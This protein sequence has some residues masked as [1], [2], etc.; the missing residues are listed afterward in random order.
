MTSSR[1]VYW[2]ASVIIALITNEPGRGAASSRLFEGIQQAPGRIYISTIGIA[3]CSGGQSVARLSGLQLAELNAK[4]RGFFRNQVF[5][6]VNVDP[7]IAARAQELQQWCLRTQKSK[8]RPFDAIH[9]ATALHVHAAEI[10]PYDGDLLRLN[11][12]VPTNS[13]RSL[14]VKTP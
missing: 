2:N 1:S 5:T 13:D 4:I 14:I 10:Y 6:M 12:T 11:G 3:E 7:V 8:L 9:V